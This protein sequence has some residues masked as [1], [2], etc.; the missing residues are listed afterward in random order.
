MN[1]GLALGL[2]FVFRNGLRRVLLADFVEL[3]ER[4]VKIAH[5]AAFVLIVRFEIDFS[6][7][8]GAGVDER[9]V[10]LFV[11]GFD[12]LLLVG[13]FFIDGG[14]LEGPDAFEA[15]LVDGHLNDEPLFDKVPGLEFG[16]EMSLIFF[17]GFFRSP[18]R[19]TILLE[20]SP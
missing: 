9:G 6:G 1:F 18:S 2:G 3:A 19:T 8:V 16:D 10:P 17:P 12:Q 15:P 14:G 5:E 13:G 7:V 4:A 20:E 11:F